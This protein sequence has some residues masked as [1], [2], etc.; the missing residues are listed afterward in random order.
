[1]VKVNRMEDSSNEGGLFVPSPPFLPPMLV[2]GNA[3][4]LQGVA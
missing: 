4:L 2:T 1:M 3:S